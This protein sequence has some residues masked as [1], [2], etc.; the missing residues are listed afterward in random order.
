M[1]LRSSSTGVRITAAA[2]MSDVISRRPAKTRPMANSALA[3][4]AARRDR[5]RTD[6][7]R[8]TR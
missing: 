7:R 6:G 2:A 3:A 5:R 1:K 4:I 8:S